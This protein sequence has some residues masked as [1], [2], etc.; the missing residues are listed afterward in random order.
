[1]DGAERAV[2]PDMSE[3]R[4]YRAVSKL[5]DSFGNVNA[6]QKYVSMLAKDEPEHVR[7]PKVCVTPRHMNRI[8]CI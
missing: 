2:N 4:K 7:C 5:L 3:F 8:P 1:M 6:P